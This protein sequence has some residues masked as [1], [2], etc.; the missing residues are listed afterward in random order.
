MKIKFIAKSKEYF[1]IAPKPVLV[2]VPDWYNSEKSYNP[3]KGVFQ[4]NPT[5][6]IKKCLPVIDSMKAGYY[7]VLPCDVWVENDGEKIKFEYAWDNLQLVGGQAKMQYENYPI[8]SE[9]YQVAFKWTNYWIIKTPKNWSSLFIHPLHYDNLPYETL[10]A[11]VDTDKFPTT[12]NFPFIF[13][14]DFS[15]LIPKGTPIV[16]VIPF[17]RETVTCEYSYDKGVLKNLWDKAHTEFFNRYGKNFFSPKKY[18][19]P[20]C[21]FSL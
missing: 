13:R 19:E 14:K 6:T 16:Q 11:I 4:G 3:K 15:G 10:S 1:D 2:S 7:L 12:I 17:K 9:Y 5:S 8:P 21:P 20:K 18:S